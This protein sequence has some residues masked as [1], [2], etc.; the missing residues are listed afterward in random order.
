MQQK[1]HSRDRYGINNLTLLL[2]T[3]Y[4]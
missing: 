3:I 2:T 4:I 1:F